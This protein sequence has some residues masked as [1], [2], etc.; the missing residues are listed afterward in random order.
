MIP[1]L[2]IFDFDGVIADSLGV[3]EVCTFAACREG[4]WPHVSTRADFLRL[5]ETNMYDG[6]HVAGV[7]PEDIPRLMALLAPKL[8]AQAG[9]CELFPGMAD[10]LARLSDAGRVA[11]VTSNLTPVVAGILDRHKVA[12]VGDVLGADRGTGKVDKIA[13]LRQESPDARCYYVGDTAGDMVEGRQA[14]AITV[15]VSWGWHPVS[16]LAATNPDFIVHT[17]QELLARLAPSQS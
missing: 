10:V 13:R 12:G 2:Y 14:G 1:P 4:G 9:Q 6:L 15:A 5:F 16:A 7:D 11:V 8:E 3:F 17:P